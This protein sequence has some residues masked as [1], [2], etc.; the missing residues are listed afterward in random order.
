M[1]NCISSNINNT[2]TL[3]QK[4]KYNDVVG[5]LNWVK[6]KSNIIVVYQFMYAH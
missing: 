6:N 1:I 3:I 2:C 4:Y 5:K